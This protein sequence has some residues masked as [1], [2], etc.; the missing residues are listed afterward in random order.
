MSLQLTMT[1]NSARILPDAMENTLDVLQR[2]ATEKASN[3]F[4]VER[5][6]REGTLTITF[7]DLEAL[8]DTQ[9]LWLT[10]EPLIVSWDTISVSDEEDQL[11]RLI[12]NLL[13]NRPTRTLESSQQGQVFLLDGDLISG[14][15]KSLTILGWGYIT[16]TD[17]SICDVETS[18]QRISLHPPQMDAL[19]AAWI[20]HCM[21]R[22]ASTREE[23]LQVEHPF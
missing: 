4:K 9:R 6:S 3:H 15:W 17:V 22:Y 13:E 19:A 16:L 1:V 14:G 20:E 8:T 12:T 5:E 18:V 23:S 10:E 11:G 7:F 2:N 21:Q